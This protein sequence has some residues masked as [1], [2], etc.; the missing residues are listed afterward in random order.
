LGFERQALHA[1][2][3]GFQHPVSGE[4]I[5]FASELP[6]DMQ[7]LIDQTARLNR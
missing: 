3:L 4:W 7:E 2:S 5:E 6:A 1:A